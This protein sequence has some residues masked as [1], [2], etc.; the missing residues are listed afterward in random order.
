MNFT[1]DGYKVLHDVQKK[2]NELN[3]KIDSI[4]RI[5]EI[6]TVYMQY[7]NKMADMPESPDMSAM[8]DILS[9][10][11]GMQNTDDGPSMESM[12]RDFQEALKDG[13]PPPPMPEGSETM[14]PIDFQKIMNAAKN[15]NQQMSQEEFDQ[16]F[17]TLKQGKSP[18]E[19]ARME[20]MVQLAKSFMK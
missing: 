8:A 3:Q 1:E 12:F 13:S 7:S 15:S 6:M 20:Q 18:E 9:K 17:D 14:N 16:L 11:T 19:V 10:M 4:I 2:C 5:M